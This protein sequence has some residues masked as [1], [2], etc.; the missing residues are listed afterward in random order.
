M[1][2]AAHVYMNEI[3]L[4]VVANASP[5]KRERG[6]AEYGSFQARQTDVDG[7]GFHVQAMLCHSRRVSAEKLV[8]P[9]RAIFADDLQLG[10][11]PSHR[12]Y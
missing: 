7:F 4:G 5:M 2:H 11:R 1:T 3:G 10:A 8:A 6:I 9:R 12:R